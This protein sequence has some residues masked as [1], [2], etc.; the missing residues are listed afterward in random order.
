M[1]NKKT[2]M[3][4]ERKVL[5]MLAVDGWWAHFLS[6]DKSGAQPF[7]I[8]AI[9]NDAVLALDCKTCADKSFSFSRIEDNQFMAF[10]SLIWKTNVFCGFVILHDDDIYLLS[11]TD[12]LAEMKKG[13]GSV[14]L[15][16]EYIQNASRYFKCYTN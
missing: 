5:D 14:K 9:K 2:G 4:F 7:D 15:T 16:E 1:N 13:R 11:F 10:Q 12:I 8:I 3:K 6:P